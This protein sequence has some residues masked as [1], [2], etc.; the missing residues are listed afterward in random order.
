MDSNLKNKKPSGGAFSMDDV[1]MLNK[2][3]ALKKLKWRPSAG[4]T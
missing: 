2:P 4:D 1:A 3:V